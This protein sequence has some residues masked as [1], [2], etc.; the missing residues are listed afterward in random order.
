[1]FSS[2]DL[3]LTVKIRKQLRTIS[4]QSIP[5]IDYLVIVTFNYWNAQNRS[6]NFLQQIRG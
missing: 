1:M 4:F 6:G 5:K 2:I 3:K